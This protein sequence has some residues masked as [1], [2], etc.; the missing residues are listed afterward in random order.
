MAPKNKTSVSWGEDFLRIEC[1]VSHIRGFEKHPMVVT[2]YRFVTPQDCDEYITHNVNNRSVSKGR[3]KMMMRILLSGL[4]I[5]NAEALIFDIHGNLVNGQKRVLACIETGI[6]FPTLII[7]GIDPA[8]IPTLDTCQCRT[9]ADM[10]A[11]M[12]EANRGPLSSSIKFTWAFINHREAYAN[13]STAM[14]GCSLEV[15]LDV[16]EEH[17]GLRE[18]VA[19]ICGMNARII[20]PWGYTSAAHYLA[21]LYDKKKADEYFTAVG[22]GLGLTRDNPAT[23]VR[24]K[25]EDIRMSNER[26]K[27]SPLCILAI[28]VQGWNAFVAGKKKPKRLGWRKG[29]PFPGILTVEGIRDDEKKGGSATD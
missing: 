26:T 19:F 24:Q 2:E 3:L 7:R 10:L 11:M 27:P 14:N 5:F 18:S 6:G 25:L 8:A 16:F 4:F 1:D 17:E 29:E 21:A 15:G 22:G 20:Q 12:G 9:L 28:I 23:A 13:S